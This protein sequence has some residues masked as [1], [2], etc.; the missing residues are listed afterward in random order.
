MDEPLTLAEQ[1]SPFHDLIIRYG[2]LVEKT[3]GSIGSRERAKRFV[4]DTF[5]AFDYQCKN[6]IIRSGFREYVL[7]IF[8]KYWGGA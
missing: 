4:E 6:E 1:E 5:C 2:K 3:I 7:N 8:E